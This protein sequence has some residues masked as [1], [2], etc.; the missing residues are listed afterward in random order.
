MNDRQEPYGAQRFV[1]YDE[2][3]RPVYEDPYAPGPDAYGANPAAYGGHAATEAPG[4]PL[5]PEYGYGSPDG[6]VA[7]EGSGAQGYGY[8]PYQG[9]Q[10]ATAW[11]PQQQAF[12]DSA[13]QSY[14]PHPEASATPYP[15]S[16]P[17]TSYPE[18]SYPAAPAYDESAAY[19]PY[20][21]Q[22]SF[23]QEP[24][25][26]Q[27]AAYGTHAPYPSEPE[28]DPAPAPGTPSP[29]GILD[30]SGRA[31]DG[32]GPPHAAERA[33]ESPADD[34]EPYRTEQ[35]SFI[36]EE[37][38]QSE[39]VIDWMKFSESRTERREEAKRRGRHRTIALVVAVLLLV[40]GGTGYLWSAGK[41]PFMGEDGTEAAGA[42]AE[43]PDV[44]V[45]HLRDIDTENVSTALLVRNEAAGGSTTVLLPN[46]LA[47][48][49]TDG[50][51]TTL[52]QSFEG[53][54]AGATREALGTLLGATFQ[55]TWRLD[56]PFLENL[57]E[58]VGGITLD[59]DSTVPAAEKDEPPLV[60]E[61][62]DR[63]LGGP[64]AVAYATHRAEDE[65][66]TRQLARFGQVIH[67]VLEKLSTDPAAATETVVAL[68]QIP[69]PS[70]TDG[71]LGGA[72]A[73]LAAHARADKLETTLLPVEQNGTLSDETARGLVKEVLGGTVRNSDP[74]AAVSVSV[75]D[76][77]GEEGA[78]Q[79]AQITLING[80]YTVVPARQADAPA[81]DST[82]TY[83]DE[84]DAEK[85]E[86]VAKTLGLPQ[87]AVRQG[88]GAANADVTV[89]LGTDFDS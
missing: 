58:A 71:Q 82:V 40:V 13:Q 36:E 46:S 72:L 89:V 11:M 74:G 41:L 54:G 73:E 8:D 53:Q 18:A 55:G 33:G 84:A 19:G 23:P 37:S 42:G 22:P 56:T 31:E 25:Y 75:R 86:E 77:T 28:A 45:L 16:Y 49:T 57:V 20:G 63:D 43:R 5:A 85:A 10:D 44:V 69:D 68:G 51:T 24:G 32:G 52:G 4:Q 15:A 34:G 59:A 66:Q 70:L 6:Y 78:A 26:G 39:D 14:A 30:G 50:T 1:G 81:D 79:S 35:F 76:A 9:G 29:E 38:G 7:P 48:T 27:Q 65:E 3:G 12:P 88:E 62:P 64:A 83:A 61:G 60:A 80:G 21:Q 87:D 2:Y 17:E 47:L 67:A